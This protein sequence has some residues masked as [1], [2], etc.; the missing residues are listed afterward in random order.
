VR[1]A[2]DRGLDHQPDDVASISKTFAAAEIMV[3]AAP[4][5]RVGRSAVKDVHHPLAANGATVR[6]LLGMR[7][8]LREFSM[9]EFDEL[10]RAW[11]AYC[12]KH[13]TP[14]PT[15]TYYP[16][17]S[18]APGNR[19]IYSSPGYLLLAILM[20]NVTGRDPAD[21]YRADLFARAGLQR[22]AAPPGQRPPAPLAALPA[23]E[24][25]A[26]S[27]SSAPCPSIATVTANA[28]AGIIAD[29]PTIA[30][31]GYQ[32]Y[33]GRLLPAADLRAMTTP[34]A[35]QDIPQIGYG[36]GTMVF[37]ALLGV[38]SS[39]GHEGT[40]PGFNTLLAVAPARHLS[41]GRVRHP[42]Q[43]RHLRDHPRPDRRKHSR[44]P[45]PEGPGQ[46]TACPRQ[47]RRRSPPATCTR[48]S[49]PNATHRSSLGRLP[50]ERRNCERSS[51][52]ATG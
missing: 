1:K 25:K 19:S 35:D 47:P 48:P 37:H 41:V 18:S 46:R 4:T 39:V 36:L 11:L 52:S 45:Y 17:T 28:S 32:L 31:W 5:A 42:E 20:R 12:T 15:L 51:T 38:D 30:H 13:W 23:S 10:Y 24:R 21:L 29:A 16:G 33:G 50:G 2:P 40:W 34:S 3:L 26:N 8:G 49:T 43:Q 22:I 6:Q 7:G 44:H 14:E 9:S 27:G